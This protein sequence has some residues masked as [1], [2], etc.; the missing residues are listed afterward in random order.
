M[1]VGYQ[2]PNKR[3]RIR[4]RLHLDPNVR[5]VTNPSQ[6]SIANYNYPV[7]FLALWVQSALQ[8]CSWTV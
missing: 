4:E 7:D 3:T 1:L 8:H 5:L 2:E 6:T